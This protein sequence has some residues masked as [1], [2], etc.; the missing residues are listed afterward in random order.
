MS[1]LTT[2]YPKKISFQH[3]GKNV[4]LRPPEYKDWQEWSHLRKENMSYLKPWEP[5]WNIHEL[6]R[7]HFVK[8][9]RFF[10]KLS[11]N[12]EAYSFLIFEKPNLQLIGEININ[13]VQR[14]VVQ[15]CSIGY[16]IS[17]NK[18]GLGLMSEAIS[19]IKE[20]SFDELELHRIEAACLEKNQRS[21]N[22]LKKNHFNI[23][24]VARKY[25]KINGK[26][27]DHVLLSC[28]NEKHN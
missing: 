5:T 2:H 13:N 17:E 11:I 7:S 24:G 21:L 4:F 26:W 23:E 3:Q 16:W 19:L 1:F 28:I 8:R 20:F 6:E 9:V 27:Q 15:S 14:G 12:D 10:E 18:M 25:L 22:T